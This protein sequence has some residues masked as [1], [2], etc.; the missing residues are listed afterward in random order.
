MIEP[1]TRVVHRPPDPPF[2]LAEAGDGRPVLVL[3]GGG[4]PFTVQSLMAH[5]SES[6]PWP[7]PAS[8]SSPTPATSLR[9]SNPKRPCT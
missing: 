3:H 2:D 9:S 8:R 6:K 4:G 7:T 5:L 1:T